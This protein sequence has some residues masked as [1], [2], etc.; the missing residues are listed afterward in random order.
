MLLSFVVFL[1]IGAAP[2]VGAFFGLKISMQY[3]RRVLPQTV[4]GF[5]G[6]AAVKLFLISALLPEA[7]GHNI[8]TFMITLVIHSLEFLA[9]K[10]LLSSCGATSNEKVSFIAYWWA[11]LSAFSSNIL[12]FASNARA[13]ELE[14]PHIVHAISVSSSLFLYFATALIAIS[15]SS[16]KSEIMPRMNWKQQI[17]V[18]SL[19]LPAACASIDTSSRLPSYVP[20]ILKLVSSGLIWVAAKRLPGK[21][22][23][24]T[25]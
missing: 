18:L 8:Q 6:A 2:F 20:D 4:A 3:L 9:V 21:Q 22:S 24:K 17:L 7:Q 14:L 10:M 11:C 23:R 19:G 12:T 1:T 16:S 5:F 25:D 13:E 15:V